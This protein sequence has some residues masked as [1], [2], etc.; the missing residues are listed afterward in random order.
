MAYGY[1]LENGV[2]AAGGGR[3]ELL[4]L[5]RSGTQNAIK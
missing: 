5:T 1:G 2:T 3:G 4:T